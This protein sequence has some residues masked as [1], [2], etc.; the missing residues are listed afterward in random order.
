[1]VGVRVEDCASGLHP[2]ALVAAPAVRELL[3]LD[4]ARDSRP[5]ARDPFQLGESDHVIEAPAD[6]LTGPPARFREA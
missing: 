5:G 3:D 4:A 6:V 2:S 1:M